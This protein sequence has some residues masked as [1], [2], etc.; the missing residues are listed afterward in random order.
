MLILVRIQTQSVCMR[1][2]YWRCR[3]RVTLV[4]SPWRA[5]VACVPRLKQ[6]HSFS[7]MLLSQQPKT[8][9]FSTPTMACK[10]ATTTPH[11]HVHIAVAR[12]ASVK[13]SPPIA[14]GIGP[15]THSP[16]TLAFTQE[17]TRTR[18]HTY[19]QAHARTRTRGPRFEEIT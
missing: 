10:H 17:R 7:Q 16:T 13:I 8:T 15:A 3:A 1:S 9:S 6:R 18:I 4:R 14:Q 12:G 19:T 11:Q 5:H 2:K